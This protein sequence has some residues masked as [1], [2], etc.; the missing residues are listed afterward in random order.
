MA[1]GINW[2]SSTG[3][4][5][6]SAAASLIPGDYKLMKPDLISTCNAAVKQ[7]KTMDVEL[8]IWSSPVEEWRWAVICDSSTD[9]S[10]KERHQKGYLIAITNPYLN[11][12][13]QA[14][15]S[16]IHWRSMRHTPTLPAMRCPKARV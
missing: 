3:R 13:M 9:T 12:A 14:P 10:G 6:L 16:L 7:A 8:R 4:P 11:K 1:C 2:L 15:I 5:D